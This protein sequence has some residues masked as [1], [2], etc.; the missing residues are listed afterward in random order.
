MQVRPDEMIRG[1][2]LTER[3]LPWPARRCTCG[4]RTSPTWMFSPPDIFPSGR[5]LQWQCDGVYRTVTMD[6]VITLFGM[7]TCILR[8]VAGQGECPGFSKM[9]GEYLS[10]RIVRGRNVQGNVRF[11]GV[12]Q[13]TKCMQWR[14]VSVALT[15]RE[16]AKN[17]IT[18]TKGQQ[19]R[20]PGRRLSVI[21]YTA[22]TAVVHRNPFMS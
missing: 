8:C 5:M 17:S 9:G 18:R 21:G 7:C 6:L 11:Y 14:I 10:G 4:C 15:G 19:M 20:R 12:W 3:D 13:A 2:S 16:Y 22:K 1:L